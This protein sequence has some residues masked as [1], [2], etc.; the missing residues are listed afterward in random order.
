MNTEDQEMETYQ[1][2]LVPM[3]NPKITEELELQVCNDSV[4]KNIKK[5]IQG[6]IC[7]T[8]KLLRIQNHQLIG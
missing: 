2:F 5:K 6:M 8:K 1:I 7:M 3:D 4:T